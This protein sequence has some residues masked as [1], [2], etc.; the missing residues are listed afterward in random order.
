[1]IR[2]AQTYLV[3]AVSGTT[4]IV[5]AVVAFVLLISFQALRDWPLAA[6][7]GGD[8]G[9]VVAPAR[10][11]HSGTS[12]AVGAA[13][14]GSRSAGGSKRGADNGAG[15]RLGARSAQNTSSPVASVPATTT[16]GTAPS[17]AGGGET[18][19]ASSGSSG[20]GPASGGGGGG[21]TKPSSGGGGSGGG[22]GGGANTP[23][24]SETVTGTVDKTVSG[25]DQATGGALGKTG[26]TQTTEEVVDGVAG[27]ESASAKRST[28]PSKDQGNGRR[29]ARRGPLDRARP[30][31]RHNAVP[32]PSADRQ[33]R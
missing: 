31:Y 27:P 25:V 5:A 26:V 6:L 18:N 24:T 21:S 30:L 7:G 20:G 10:G 3:G 29:P 15:G 1:M 33:A 8:S 19:S 11:R 32:C 13:A 14:N 17:P 9:G 4:L 23:S 16:P 2:Q 12:A 22:A 28:R